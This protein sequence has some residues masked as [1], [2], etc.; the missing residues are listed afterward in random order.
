MVAWTQPLL[1]LVVGCIVLNL[2]WT[3]ASHKWRRRPGRLFFIAAAL[4][5]SLL[6]IWYSIDTWLDGMRSAG[7]HASIPT[8]TK[9][10]IA[11]VE[12]GAVLSNKLIEL[13]FLPVL[14]GIFGMAFSF[15]VEESSKLR[16]V[17]LAK[18]EA[19][20]LNCRDQ[21]ASTRTEL[22]ALLDATPRSS[23]DELTAAISKCAAAERLFLRSLDDLDDE[24]NE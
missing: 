24:M 13:F 7:L 22:E 14:V 18:L 11:Q 3:D 2:V 4:S 20:V 12:R 8:D 15:K 17:H 10:F 16:K 5:F 6:G 1:L 21:L 23:Y 19:S 9:E